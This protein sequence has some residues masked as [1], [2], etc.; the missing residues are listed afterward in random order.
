MGKTKEEEKHESYGLL[1]FNRTTNNFGAN[2]FGSKIK[3]KSTVSM[4]VYHARKQRNLNNDHYFTDGHNPIIE[5]EMSLNQFAEAISG[6]NQGNGYP[7]TIRYIEGKEIKP[8][9]EQDKHLEL[10]QEEFQEKIKKIKKNINKI[11][12]ETEKLLTKKGRINKGEVESINNQISNIQQDIESNIPFIQKQ[13]KEQTE[14]I[15]H[16]AKSE[17]EAFI[18]NKILSLGKEKI[19][20]EMNKI[21]FIEIEEP[22]Q[23]EIPKRFKLQI[24]GEK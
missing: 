18:N 7:V 16:E 23:I 12:N 14:G 15:I 17:V 21:K 6:P 9:P 5:I 4:R 8:C 22:K 1:G 3:H 10:F 19:I 20:E 13:F 2:L 24:K 11:V